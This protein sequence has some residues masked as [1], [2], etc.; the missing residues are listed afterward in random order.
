MPGAHGVT[1]AAHH[2]PGHLGASVLDAPG[3]REYHTLYS[4]ADRPA[5]TPGW[6]PTSGASG[7]Q[8]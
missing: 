3:S 6:T 5:W 7:W 1:T 2:F 8:R 4:F